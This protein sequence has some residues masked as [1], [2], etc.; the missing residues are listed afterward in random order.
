MVDE[1]LNAGDQI[2]EAATTDGLLD[3]QSEPAFYQ[4]ESGS[5]GRRVMDV[6]A[7]PL[8]QPQTH[9]GMLV[10]GVVVHYKMDIKVCGYALV[11]ALEKPEKL[12]MGCRGLHS[13]KTAP[14][15]ISSA[16][17][18]VVASRRGRDRLASRIRHR[19]ERRRV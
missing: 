19:D 9:P 2:A 1:V 15:A 13:V 14:V 7:G 11:D 12:L 8:R 5:V 17:N 16:A 18:S 3:D 6:E 4:V 10:G